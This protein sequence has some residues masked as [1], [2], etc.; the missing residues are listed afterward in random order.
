MTQPSTG[1]TWDAAGLGD[2]DNRFLERGKLVAALIRDARGAATDISPHN[3][4]GSV[5]WSPFAQDGKWRQDLF[6]FKRVNGFWVTNTDANEGFHFTGAFKDGD[7]PSQKPKI[8][9]DK[10]MILQSNHP[11]DV[12]TVSEEMPFSFTGVETAKPLMRRLRNNLPLND[13]ITGAVL[14]EDPGLADAVWCKP[15]NA[16]NVDRQVLLVRERSIN[17]QKIRTVEGYALAKLTDM[18]ESKKDKKDSE[19]AELT[20]E[21]LP[22]G[23]FMGMVDG[24]YRPILKATWVAGEGWA[25]LGGVPTISTTPPTATAGTTG[26]AS[27]SFADPTGTGDPWVISA[28]STTDDGT[29][30]AAATLD[31]PGAVVSAGGSTTVK[32]KSVTAGSTKFRAKVV[33]TNGASAYTPKSNAVTIT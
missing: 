27:F 10:F 23:F 24:E 6:A 11:F 14:V 1:T 21:P 22:D 29:T 5:R 13:P 3:S 16:D 2:T 4:D 8:D 30:W 26:K 9:A 32:V 17:G 19:A 31:T 33:G 18:G 20:Y 12:D 15:L 25:A 7:G 28:E